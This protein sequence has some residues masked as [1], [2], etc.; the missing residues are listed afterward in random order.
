MNRSVVETVLGALVLLVA[1][2]FLAFSY[3]TADV[4]DVEG[5]EVK[6]NFSSIGGLKAGDDVMISGVKVGQI[7]KVELDPKT[8][9]ARITMELDNAVRLPEDTAAMISS[10]SLLGGRYLSIEPGGAEETIPA[11]GEIQFTQAP[12]NL[13]ELLG[14]FIF[15]MKN[16]SKE[17]ETSPPESPVKPA[18]EI[19]APLSEGEAPIPPQNESPSSNAPAHISMP[20][21][22]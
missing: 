6:A 22:P 3:Q 9:L 14:K 5:Y 13:E 17:E 20:E 11:G 19:S 15:S 2:V 21:S 10:Q 1:G 18:P 4:A 7:A 16:G 8:Y 12:Q